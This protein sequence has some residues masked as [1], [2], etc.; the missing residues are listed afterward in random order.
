M[1]TTRLYRFCTAL[2]VLAL[3]GC[4]G[5]PMQYSVK[6]IYVCA[7]EECTVA[8]RKYSAGQLSEGLHELLQLNADQRVDV[9]ESNPSTRTCVSIGACHFVQGG[10]FPGLGCG[11]GITFHEVRLDRQAGQVLVKAD[12]Y[13]TFLGITL[14]CA[15]TGA[16]FSIRSVDE[17][18]YVVE[19][20]MCN[21]LGIGNMTSTFNLAVESIDFDRG[22]IGGYWQHAVAGTGGGS[23][24]GYLV[25]RFP[26]P[27]PAGAG[28]LGS[29]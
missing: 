29:K 12:D 21:W 5:T 25:L 22:L 1:D 18:T 13:A 28:W 6:E 23:G 11:K 26:K 17:V 19:P 9:C 8:N 2:A 27:M 20:Y 4:A 16:S 3:T 15:T 24:S 14:G 10:P 7:G